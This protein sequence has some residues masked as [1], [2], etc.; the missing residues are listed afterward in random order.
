MFEYISSLFCSQQE[1][2]KSLIRST[3]DE[4]VSIGRNLRQKYPVIQSYMTFEYV[5]SLE[6]EVRREF[7]DCGK[8]QIEVREEL[9]NLIKIYC[10]K[11]PDEK[12]CEYRHFK[13]Y[14]KYP[15]RLHQ[16]LH[17]FIKLL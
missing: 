12:I 9:I 14:D 16:W 4:Y 10:K 1:I 15:Y 2:Y 3:Y 17:E 8:R 6:E 7:K 11:Y 13:T 5:E